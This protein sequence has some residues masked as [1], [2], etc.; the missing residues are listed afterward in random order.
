VINANPPVINFCGFAEV[1]RGL[2]TSVSIYSRQQII[3]SIRE[4]R[5]VE[6]QEPNI[7]VKV[8]N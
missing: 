7:S 1:N 3:Y 4:V 6:D 2:F 5:A 8:F